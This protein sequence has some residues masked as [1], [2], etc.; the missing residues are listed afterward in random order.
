[1]ELFSSILAE[2]SQKDKTY[3]N[4]LG[5]ISEELKIMQQN[6]NIQVEKSNKVFK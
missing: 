4:I 6:S 5:P 3:M 2:I 1:M